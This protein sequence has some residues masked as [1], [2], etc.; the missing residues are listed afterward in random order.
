MQMICCD[1][2]LS[3]LDL[4]LL[5]IQRESENSCSKLTFEVIIVYDAFQLVNQVPQLLSLCNWVPEIYTFFLFKLV[6]LL[7]V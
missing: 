2:I 5:V 4:Q 3:Q 6:L 7:K 1:T